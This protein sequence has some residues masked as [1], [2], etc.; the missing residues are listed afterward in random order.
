MLRSGRIGCGFDPGRGHYLF[1]AEAKG[2]ESSPQVAAV[3]HACHIPQKGQEVDEV[4][5]LKSPTE[6]E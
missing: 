1:P 5:S 3:T 2:T 6:G 4:K